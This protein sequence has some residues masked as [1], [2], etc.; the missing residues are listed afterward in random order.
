MNTTRVLQGAVVLVGAVLL[1][2]E[3]R[4]RTRAPAPDAAGAERHGPTADPSSTPLGAGAEL[5]RALRQGRLLRPGRDGLDVTLNQ[6]Y[7]A[8]TG[9]SADELAEQLE[10]LGPRVNGRP[11]WAKTNVQAGTR[12]Y[13]A[14]DGRCLPDSTR[15]EL[16]LTVLL[17]R[18]RPP[19]ATDPALRNHWVRFV[20]AASAH[21]L[22]HQDIARFYMADLL[23]GA[24]AQTSTDC[25]ELQRRL[26]EKTAEIYERHE[27]TQLRFDQET[28]NGERQS[29]RWPPEEGR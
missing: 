13:T 19:P 11:S 2:A 24:R 28:R 3:L 14:A 8:V 15:V 9:T 10:R 27:R 4:S 29:V 22:A 20:R 5:D 26:D 25:A 21:E 1:L 6:Q 23:A 16:A 12:L 18:W 7:Y 17:P